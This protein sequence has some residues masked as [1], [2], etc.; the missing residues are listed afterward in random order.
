MTGAVGFIGA[1]LVTALI[2]RFS[3]DF[4][5][6]LPWID[7][8]D[9]PRA[10]LLWS[11]RRR[12]AL[13]RRQINNKRVFFM[14]IAVVG[15]GYVGLHYNNPSFGYGGYCLPK[16]TKQLLA[17]YSDVPQN[18]ISA[19]RARTSSPIR[20]LPCARRSSASIG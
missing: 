19:T 6:V 20:S 5:K 9:R 18:M 13:R 17:N 3:P 1:H 11:L 7:P 2:E 15:T 10:G 4:R 8:P 12:F 16:E 14:R